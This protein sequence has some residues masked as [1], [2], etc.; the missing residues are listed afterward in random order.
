[1]NN[2]T[3]SKPLIKTAIENFFTQYPNHGFKA[4]YIAKK[5]KCRKTNVYQ[6][7]FQRKDLVESINTGT[8]TYYLLREEQQN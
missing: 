1:M 8:S 6:F 4:D 5:L 2:Q 3:E 7:V